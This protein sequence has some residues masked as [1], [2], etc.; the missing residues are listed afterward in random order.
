MLQVFDTVTNCEY[1][2][3]T[4]ATSQSSIR[5]YGNHRNC[6][7]QYFEI[8]EAHQRLTFD[9]RRGGGGVGGLRH[10]FTN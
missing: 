10:F 8:E 6:G 7:A 3:R 1:M 9:V 4:K 2:S 5:Y